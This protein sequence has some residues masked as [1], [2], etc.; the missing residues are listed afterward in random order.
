LADL[1]RALVPH[2]IVPLLFRHL[3]FLSSQGTPRNSF[4]EENEELLRFMQLAAPIRSGRSNRTYRG[5][6]KTF[7]SWY[8]SLQDAHGSSLVPSCGLCL[9]SFL[10]GI[11]G[12]RAF[13]KKKFLQAVKREGIG[14]EKGTAFESDDYL[15]YNTHKN[16]LEDL[17]NQMEV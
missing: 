2:H 15:D 12:R 1:F 3:T 17:E 5:T 7:Y 6:K 11:S 10:L 9:R 14:Y 4:K 8:K 13:K 16:R